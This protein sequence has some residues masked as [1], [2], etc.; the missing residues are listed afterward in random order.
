[1]PTYYSRN[2][3]IQLAVADL[4]DTTTIS[5][6][7]RAHSTVHFEVTSC[8]AKFARASING[9]LDEAPILTEDA[10]QTHVRSLG[11]FSE[12]PFFIVRA[13]MSIFS[14]ELEG[15]RSRRPARVPS[16]IKS[17]VFMPRNST[18]LESSAA[19]H[20]DEARGANT[21]GGCAKGQCVLLI[22]YNFLSAH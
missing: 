20:S 22:S 1:M 4:Q 7:S 10:N 11:K 8:A 18:S 6:E 13:G 12:M 5:P 15:R 14:S 21:P 3:S 2:T 19:S 9:T 17:P 16:S